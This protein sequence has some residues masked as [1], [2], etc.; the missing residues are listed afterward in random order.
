M[1][2]YE[3]AAT[4][5]D[6]GMVK[7]HAQTMLPASPHLTADARRVAPTPMIAPVMV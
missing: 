4:S 7:I 6:A 3:S 1:T 2:Q 5:P